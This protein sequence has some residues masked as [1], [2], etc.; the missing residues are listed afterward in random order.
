MDERKRDAWKKTKPR[1]D[2][3]KTRSVAR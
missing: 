2:R 3:A 1:I